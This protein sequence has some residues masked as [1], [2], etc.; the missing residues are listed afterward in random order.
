LR[1]EWL[2]VLREVNTFSKDLL[3]KKK[4]ALKEFADLTTFIKTRWT[5]ATKWDGAYYS[6]N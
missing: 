2:R 3:E 4:A 1:K 5:R 6:E